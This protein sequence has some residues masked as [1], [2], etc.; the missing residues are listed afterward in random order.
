[1][2]RFYSRA[3]LLPTHP[4]PSQRSQHGKITSPSRTYSVR[5]LNETPWPI[6]TI[7]DLKTWK[8]AEGEEHEVEVNAWVKNVRKGAAVRFIDLSDGSSMR[9]VQA[10]VDRTLPGAM[11]YVGHL[12]AL[13]RSNELTI[14]AE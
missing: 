9:P 8:P 4:R 14:V 2:R 7:A 6:R 12:L 1:M 3:G 5:A 13:E 10:V 11:E